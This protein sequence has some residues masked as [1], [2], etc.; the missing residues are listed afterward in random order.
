MNEPTQLPADALPE[1]GSCYNYEGQ[2]FV[3]T[4]VEPS[5]F[6][7]LGDDAEWTDAVEFT[8]HVGEGETAMVSYVMAADL[9]AESYAL[10]VIEEGAEVDN[11][12]PDEEAPEVD[13][14][15]PD[16]PSPEPKG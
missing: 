1:V 13:N 12:L 3:V 5:R 7:V 10:G 11:E 4:R 8:D 15:L 9:F 2:N 16:E 6:L 14:E